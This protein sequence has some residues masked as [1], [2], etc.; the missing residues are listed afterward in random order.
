M[1]AKTIVQ[2]NFDHYLHTM[3]AHAWRH[4]TS[5]QSRYI[6]IRTQGRAGKPTAAEKIADAV[7]RT[8][9]FHAAPYCGSGHVP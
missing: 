7:S 2:H 8:L 9:Q 5:N 6:Y 4:G 1:A 3:Y